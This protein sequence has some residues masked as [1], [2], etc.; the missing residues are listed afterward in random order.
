MLFGMV[1]TLLFWGDV[2]GRFEVNRKVPLLILFM[3]CTTGAFG[4]NLDPAPIFIFLPSLVC[5][6]VVLHRKKSI[7]A[8]TFIHV[9]ATLVCFF[10]G[11]GT[12]ELDFVPTL[13]LVG[14]VAVIFS[15]SILAVISNRKYYYKIANLQTVLERKSHSIE[16]KS[17]MLET[18]NE[19]LKAAQ[20]QLENRIEENS[21][22]VQN[23]SSVN[24][25]LE[26]IAKAAS[27]DLKQPLKLIGKHTDKL[28]ERLHELQLRD[29]FKEYL[30][31]VGDGASRMNAMVDDLLQYCDP[32]M[33]SSLVKVST[34]EVLGQVESNLSNLLLREN[35]SL[36]SQPSMPEIV[37]HKTEVLQL[38]QNLISNGIKFRRPGVLPICTV[39]FTRTEEAICFSVS[40]NGIG[41]PANRVDDIFGLFTRL[42]GRGNYEGTGIGLALCRRIVIAA[43][44]KIWAES[45]EGEGTTFFFTWPICKEA[46]KAIDFQLALGT[47]IHSEP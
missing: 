3:L 23:L 21:I 5:S 40:D 41:I 37:G 4:F 39:G 44:G 9:L 2:Y 8:A 47:I 27:S 29:D 34:S 42:H 18:R 22:R 20:V 32:R 38:F 30:D 16:L 28:G 24:A 35:A 6:L 25:E 10:R 15:A 45:K 12:V 46:A 33:K 26:L 11:D 17:R 31:F 13:V 43:G 1:S 19:E 36:I 14:V 7:R